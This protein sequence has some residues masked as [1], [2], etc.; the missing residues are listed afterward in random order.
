MEMNTFAQSWFISVVPSV[1]ADA[2]L[3]LSVI[4]TTG[5]L[6]RLNG[7]ISGH[8]DLSLVRGTINLSMLL[9]IIYLV[10]VAGAL[11]A[12]ILSVTIW[13]MPIFL[14]SCHM[15]LFGILTLP[16][17]FI[18]KEQEKKV[19]KLEVTA[20]DPD[21]AETYERWLVQWNQPRIQLPD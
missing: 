19:R 2:M 12:L 9:A 18:G 21:V 16:L 6:A 5:V 10:L 1:L 7:E 11:V 3:V 13:N 15:G 14:A 20:Q 4:K 17:G 8:S